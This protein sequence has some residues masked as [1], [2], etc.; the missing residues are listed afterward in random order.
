MWNTDNAIKKLIGTPRKKG[1]R[2]DWDG[3]GIPNK[4]DCQPRN[5]MRQD[6]ERAISGKKCFNCGRVFK[7]GENWYYWYHGDQ[8]DRVCKVCAKRLKH[9]DTAYQ[10]LNVLR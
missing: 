1:G 8:D 4:R 7:P 5:T 2:N 10:G 9:T 6:G 3:D